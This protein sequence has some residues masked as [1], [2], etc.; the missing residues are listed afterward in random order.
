MFVSSKIYIWDSIVKRFFFFVLTVRPK[1]LLRRKRFNAT[2]IKQVPNRIINE[3]KALFGNW[4]SSVGMIV[5]FEL[6]GIDCFI[7]DEQS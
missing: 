7:D 5:V 4:L 3:S 6:I 1:N 2:D